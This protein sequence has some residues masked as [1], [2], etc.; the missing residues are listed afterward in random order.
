MIFAVAPMMD[1]TDA[2]C[3]A[4][5]RVLSRHAVLYSEMITADAVIHGRRDRLLGFKGCAGP[6]ALQLGG[7]D[8]ARLAEATA[9]GAA[10]GYVEVNL[11]VGCPSDRVQEGRFGACLMREPALVAECLSAMAGAAPAGVEVTVKHRLGVDDQDPE[12]SLFGFVE[13]VA[14]A[15][16]R[17]FVVHARKAWLKGLSPRENRDIPPLDYAIVRRLKQARPDLRIVLNGGLCDPAT[18]RTEAAGLD[19]VMLGRAAYQRPALLL[20]VDPLF[21]DLPAPH[22]SAIEAL[23][24]YRPYV[25]DR[26]AEGVPLNAITRHVLGLFHGQPGG[27]VFRRVLSE[28]APK[29]GAGI[30]VLDAALGAVADGLKAAA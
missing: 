21:A 9:I 3:R 28:H 29:R 19:G 6:V 17:T 25:C 18:A 1:W 30:E 11:N 24:A 4:F 23:R 13:T 20:Q 22:A 16:V 14:A 8:P 12:D 10:Y 15:G 26:L 27:R 2:H 7:S 5:H